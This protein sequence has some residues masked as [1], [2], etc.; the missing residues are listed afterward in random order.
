MKMCKTYV[1][2]LGKTPIYFSRLWIKASPRP[3]PGICYYIPM[4]LAELTSG[5]CDKLLKKKMQRRWGGAFR[6]W[7]TLGIFLS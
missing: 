5:H 4:D 3:D 1:D 7:H 2:F 6:G